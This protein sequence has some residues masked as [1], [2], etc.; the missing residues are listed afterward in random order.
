[1]VPAFKLWE[2]RESLTARTRTRIKSVLKLV[3]LCGAATVALTLAPAASATTIDFSTSN[4]A[5][6][7]SGAGATD[8]T[9]FLFPSGAI[10]L[11]NNGHS[12]GTFVTGGSAA[13]FDGFWTASFSFFLPAT[14]TDAIGTLVSLTADD[15]VVLYVNGNLAADG[16]LGIPPGGSIAGKMEFTDGG[17]D[18]PFTFDSSDSS[19]SGSGGFILGGI[20][21]LVAVINNTGSGVTGT[22]KTF[23][24]DGDGATFRIQGSVTYAPEPTGISMLL[25]GCLVALARF[26]HLIRR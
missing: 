5:W 3:L 1:M 17:G 23:A 6:T 18:Q 25:G 9:P 15:R 10:S 19:G 22:T 24:G 8:A 2:L 13:A 4:G 7:V 20:N 21:T 11:S 26:R 14:A 12:S 16:G